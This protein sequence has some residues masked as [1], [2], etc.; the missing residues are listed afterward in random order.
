MLLSELLSLPG[1]GTDL[2]PSPQRKREKLFE[3]LLNQL[4]A[5]ARHQPVLIVFED[6]HW[7]DPTSRELLDLMFDRVSRMCVLLIVTFRPELQHAWGGQ[8]YVTML[9]LNRLDRRD[10]AALVEQ[11]AGDASLSPQDRR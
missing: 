6:A 11:L 3:A 1:S 4:E 10:S 9:A 5:E 7:V 8:P 2:N